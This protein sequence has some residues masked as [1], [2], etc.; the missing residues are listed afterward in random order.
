MN[1]FWPLKGEGIAKF[2]LQGICIVG[3]YCHYYRNW[4]VRVLF[5]T[6]KQFRA[7]VQ[8]N[9]SVPESWLELPAPCFNSIPEFCDKL[10][11]NPGNVWWGIC[12][13]HAM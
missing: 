2:V 9:V 10:D 1:F 8:G 12:Y 5:R 7:S 3:N 6:K 13:A 4:E 11:R